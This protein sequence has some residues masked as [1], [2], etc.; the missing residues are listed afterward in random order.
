[1]GLERTELLGPEGMHLVEPRL[2]GDEAFRPEP[3]DPASG[4]LAEHVD[5]HE[6]ALPKDP[7]VAAQRRSRHVDVVGQVTGAAGCYAQEVD[8]ASS[9]GVGECR[10]RAVEVVSDS[11]ND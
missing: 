11:V 4:V 8:D 3:V 6:P 5:V 7:K 10:K 2:Q 9:R 1:M